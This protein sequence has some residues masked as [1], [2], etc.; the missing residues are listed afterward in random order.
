MISQAEGGGI[1]IEEDI[2]YQDF[3]VHGRKKAKRGKAYAI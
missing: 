1:Q 2:V 3:I